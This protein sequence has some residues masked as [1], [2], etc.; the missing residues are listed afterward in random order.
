MKAA[1]PLKNE[2]I[3]KS[4]AQNQSMAAAR[5]YLGLDGNFKTVSPSRTR[6]YSS[7]ASFSM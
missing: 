1:R 7:R 6:P 5:A 3:A 2:E 4:V